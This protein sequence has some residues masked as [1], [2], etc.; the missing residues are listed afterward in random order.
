ME[1]TFDNRPE[2]V[3]TGL[4]VGATELGLEF[5]HFSQPGNPSTPVLQSLTAAFP[6]WIKD[7]LN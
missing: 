7:I 3:V 4:L 5:G 2:S 6:I 1:L